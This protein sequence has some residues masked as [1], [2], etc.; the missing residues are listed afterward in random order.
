MREFQRVKDD[1]G[2][3]PRAALQETMEGQLS[4]L[5]VTGHIV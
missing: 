1:G 5:C 3:R 4:C 2:G